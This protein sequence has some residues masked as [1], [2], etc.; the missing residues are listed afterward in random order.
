M[1]SAN[2]LIQKIDIVGRTIAR[3]WPVKGQMLYK[4]GYLSFLK[5]ILYNCIII[6][7]TSVSFLCVKDILLFLGPQIDIFGRTI[8]RN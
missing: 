3:N 7:K 5:S 1:V 6:Q 2:F 4:I 8:A